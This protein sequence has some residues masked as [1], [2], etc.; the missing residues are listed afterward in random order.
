[1][2]GAVCSGAGVVGCHLRD[3]RRVRRD[4]GLRQ[5]RD[6][7]FCCV[8]RRC[9]KR[10]GRDG[11]RRAVVEKVKGPDPESRVPGNELREVYVLVFQD[12]A[13]G[14]VFRVRRG[15][16]LRREERARDRRRRRWLRT[17]PAARPRAAAPYLS[18]RP[19][20]LPRFPPAEPTLISKRRP[21]RRERGERL[22]SSSGGSC[23]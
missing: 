6:E 22:G 20:S 17:R 12:D 21:L 4:L 10:R 9:R 1:M 15:E 23:L 19:R 5:W 16:A 11:R 8:P 13:G 3:A 18:P 7:D 2:F 14:D